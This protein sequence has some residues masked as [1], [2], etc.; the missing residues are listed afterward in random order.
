MLPYL[1]TSTP[2][3]TPQSREALVGTVKEQFKL[4]HDLDI[5]LQALKNGNSAQA[6]S[7]LESAQ[8]SIL[9]LSE[10]QQNCLAP[11]YFNRCSKP[12]RS[13]LAAHKTFGIT[14]LLVD[15]LRELSTADLLRV[16]Q[17]NKRMCD[18]ID[19]STALKQKLFL[20]PDPKAHLEVLPTAELYTLNAPS[21]FTKRIRQ[22]ACILTSEYQPNRRLHNLQVSFCLPL[23]KLGSRIRQMLITQPPIQQVVM[24][25]NCCEAKEREN[26][27][28]QPLL[29]K[30]VVNLAG[31]TLGELYDEAKQA[32][33]DHKNCAFASPYI[34]NADGSVDLK[35]K[36]R[37]QIVLDH[38][39]PDVVADVALQQRKG[40]DRNRV[41][42]E[43]QM[44]RDF[45]KAKA[46]GGS[47]HPDMNSTLLRRLTL[48][49]AF[50]QGNPDLTFEQFRSAKDAE[51]SSFET[52]SL[53]EKH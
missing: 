13:T 4:K 19:D 10:H 33:T 15:I 20:L 50:T 27:G 6:I 12:G 21:I 31:L 3:I 16:Q 38:D 30:R 9:R 41:K 34:H 44:M 18:V 11:E 37:T 22:S 52:M 29:A 43:Q 49:V 46:L 36:F 23:P 7:L 35:V 17:V 48:S 24:T 5:A 32:I 28:L 14:E 40:D 25:I 53:V 26:Y 42:G 51:A 1:T 39:H 8:Q 2:L 45:C 47:I